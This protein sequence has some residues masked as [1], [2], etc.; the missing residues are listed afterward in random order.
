MFKP[1]F[2]KIS[3]G[4]AYHPKVSGLMLFTVV[5]HQIDV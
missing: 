4:K 1:P 2:L 3:L 5:H